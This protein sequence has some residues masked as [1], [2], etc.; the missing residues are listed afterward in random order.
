[1][2]YRDLRIAPLASCG[3]LRLDSASQMLASKTI[4]A[5]A[6]VAPS[7]ICHPARWSSHGGRQTCELYQGPSEQVVIERLASGHRVFDGEVQGAEILVLAG[8]LRRGD[9]RLVEGTWIR[10]PPGAWLE[11]VAA[12]PATTV[13]V[14][15]GHLANPCHCGLDPA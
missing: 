4:T 7:K 1:M 11:F 5:K 6:A 3:A 13:Y 14:K 10:L 15:T 8:E 12:V 9:Q 2:R